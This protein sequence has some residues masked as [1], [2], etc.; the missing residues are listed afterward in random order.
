MVD[1]R[2]VVTTRERRRGPSGTRPCISVVAVAGGGRRH[3]AKHATATPFQRKDCLGRNR[4]GH[5]RTAAR[6]VACAKAAQP[7]P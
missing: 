6:I 2:L 4:V 3:N 5:V 7:I 1:A